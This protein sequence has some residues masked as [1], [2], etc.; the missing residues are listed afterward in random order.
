MLTN[1]HTHSLYSDGN[2]HPEEYIKQAIDKGFDL[3]GFSEHSP[4]PFD[5]T[6]SFQHSKEDEYLTLI[7]TLKS[8]Y[9]SRIQLALGM[10]IDYIPGVSEDFDALINRYSLDYS[11]GS[12]H[13]VKE[14]NQDSLWFIDGPVPEIYDSGLEEIFNG[15]IRKAV[16][17]YYRQVNEMLQSQHFDILGHMDKIKMHNQDRYFREN[18]AWYQ[19]LVK[20]TLHLIREKNVIVEVNTR[21]IYKKRSAT[22]YPG[23]EI[24]K[25]ICELQIPVMIN[26]D[27]H[28]PHE[29]IGAFSAGLEIIKEAGIRELVYYSGKGWSSYNF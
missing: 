1:H 14:R 24:L 18:E 2:S 13:L 20:E 23:P 7:A 16:S 25:Q 19:A 3:L 5:S 22:T 15:D 9:S 6:F 28:Q 21:G 26:S 27:A 8:R 12:V 10:E 17:A 4:L 11:I 29:L